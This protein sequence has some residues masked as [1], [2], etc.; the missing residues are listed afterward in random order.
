MVTEAIRQT[1]PFSSGKKYILVC[2]HCGNE[3]RDSHSTFGIAS[4][5]KYS[6]NTHC[7]VC[8]SRNKTSYVNGKDLSHQAKSLEMLINVLS[9]KAQDICNYEYIPVNKNGIV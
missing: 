7:M 9:G 5:D 4:Y 8:Y 6:V 3:E 2:Y 1:S